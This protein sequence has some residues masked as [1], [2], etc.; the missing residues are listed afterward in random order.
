MALKMQVMII[1]GSCRG[2]AY[3]KPVIKV[4]KEHRPGGGEGTQYVAITSCRQCSWQLMAQALEVWRAEAD[5]IT[6]RILL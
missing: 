2:N 4:I 5:L 3:N 6:A 1:F